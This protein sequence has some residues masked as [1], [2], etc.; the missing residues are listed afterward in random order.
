MLI[1]VQAL[2]FLP[3]SHAPRFN[4]EAQPAESSE[5]ELEPAGFSVPIDRRD[6]VAWVRL[7]AILPLTPQAH[8]AADYQPIH[9]GGPLAKLFGLPG[10]IA[11]GQLVGIK[12]AHEL[13][14]ASVKSPAANAAD[15]LWFGS[16][17]WRCSMAFKRPMPYPIELDASFGRIG[18]D[19][20]VAFSMAKGDKIHLTGGVSAI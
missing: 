6:V 9:V 19:G 12:L 1:V 4:A 15:H 17:P 18:K 13:H 8:Y 16:S 2:K 7:S 20:A 14:H 5:P 10:P 3:S 11:H